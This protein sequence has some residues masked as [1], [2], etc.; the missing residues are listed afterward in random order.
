MQHAECTTRRICI[1]YS[2]DLHL[3]NSMIGIFRS[4]IASISLVDEYLQ[5]SNMCWNP[6]DDPIPSKK[7]LK[8]QTFFRFRF[9]QRKVY[10]IVRRFLCICLWMLYGSPFEIV[11]KRD[12]AGYWKRTLFFSL[13]ESCVYANSPFVCTLLHFVPHIFSSNLMQQTINFRYT[14]IRVQGHTREPL[15]STSYELS[16]RL[17]MKSIRSKIGIN[18]SDF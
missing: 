14:K 15:T 9:L 1:T 2:A 7:Q 6:F 5:G 8:T 17:N 10:S 16:P 11:C 12:T 13:L 4:F 3:N 18:V